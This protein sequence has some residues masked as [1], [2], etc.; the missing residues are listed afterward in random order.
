M[1]TANT[2]K[3]KKRLEGIVTSDKSD[4]TIVVTVQRRYKH[5][6]YSKFLFKSA[7]YHAHDENNVAKVGDRVTI[8][9]SRPYSKNKTWE[10][11]KQ[12]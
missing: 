7:K 10:L 9:E 11:F 12:S 8:V 5:P 2:K 3:F 4:K 1:E 6:K